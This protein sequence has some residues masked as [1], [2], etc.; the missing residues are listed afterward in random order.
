MLQRKP[1][2]LTGCSILWR[3]K[4][5]R[6]T[7]LGTG[8]FSQEIFSSW[9]FLHLWKG[10]LRALSWSL[11][12]FFPSCVPIRVHC[13]WEKEALHSHPQV[14]CYRK[15][16]RDTWP[17]F[18]RNKDEERGRDPKAQHAL[19]LFTQCPHCLLMKTSLCH[20]NTSNPKHLTLLGNTLSHPTP[21]ASYYRL[22]RSF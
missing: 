9:V 2:S 10:A 7:E 12:A 20:S 11:R 4:R 15:H 3:M 6:E 16:T 5:E 21:T 8:W 18:G 14:H 17:T 22:L 13:T 1:V 19:W